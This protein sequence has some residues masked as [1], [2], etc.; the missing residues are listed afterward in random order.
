MKVSEVMSPRVEVLRPEDTLT[1]AAEQM[2][3]LDVGSMPVCDGRRVLGMLT[4]RDIVVRAVA[5]QLD[6]RT[7]QAQAC[8]SEGV[9]W[10]FED[11]DVEE[12]AQLMADRQIRRLLVLNREKDLVGFVSLG[13]VARSDRPGLSGR[14][15]DEISAPTTGGH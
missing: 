11:D 9:E 5:S 4:D 10:C 3:K 13:D 15:L 14:A 7:T 2:R 12:A 6:P 1:A 8:M